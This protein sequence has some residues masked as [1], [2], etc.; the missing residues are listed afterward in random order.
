MDFLGK[1]TPRLGLWPHIGLYLTVPCLESRQDSCRFLA[2]VLIVLPVV[3]ER[4]CREE[5]M[6]QS[7]N[8]LSIFLNFFLV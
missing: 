1:Q 8:I 5:K 3:M 6:L 7:P 2:G 4:A